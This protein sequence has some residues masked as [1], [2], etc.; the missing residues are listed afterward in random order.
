MGDTAVAV[1]SAE[2]VS[3]REKLQKEYDDKLAESIKKLSAELTESTNKQVQRA[4]EEWK[5]KL[6]PPTKEEVQTLLDQEY[7]TFSV[8]LPDREKEFTLHELPQKVEKKFYARM[9]NAMAKLA[10]EI[11]ALKM[12]A[13]ADGK[14]DLKDLGSPDTFKKVVNMMNAFD[15]ILDVLAYAATLALNPYGEEE[16]IT[17]DW[18]R[19][20][21][22]SSRIL[23][24]VKAQAECNRMRDFFSLVSRE[25][26]STM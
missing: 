20:H 15:P 16:G 11:E 13:A 18:V 6:E 19:D 23:T 10:S 7:Q 8:R 5:K 2:E 1:V 21:L 26:K 22:S 12:H 3:L 25:L 24:I 4:I 17:E 9:K 14:V